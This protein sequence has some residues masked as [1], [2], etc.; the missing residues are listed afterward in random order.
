MKYLPNIICDKVKGLNISELSYT[1]REELIKDIKIKADIE[2]GYV[3]KFNR[4]VR[5]DSFIELR[6]NLSIASQCGQ[7]VKLV[8]Q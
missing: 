3:D 5:C 4:I 6:L 2:F 7:T 1:E 8:I